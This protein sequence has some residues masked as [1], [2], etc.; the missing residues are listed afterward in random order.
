MVLMVSDLRKFIQNVLII[1]YMSV[2]ANS[3][4]KIAS[5]KWKSMEETLI[6]SSGKLPCIPNATSDTDCVNPINDKITSNKNIEKIFEEE[7]IEAPIN[8]NLIGN[9]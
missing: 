9:I 7:I 1:P 6:A 2:N 5:F 8:S 4:E 3:N